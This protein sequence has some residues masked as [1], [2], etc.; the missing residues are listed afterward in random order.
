MEPVR[1]FWQSNEDHHHPE[2]ILFSGP[3][4]IDLPS[5]FLPGFHLLVQLSAVKIT[6]FSGLA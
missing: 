6:K 4:L 1:F 2:T 5:F 3:I